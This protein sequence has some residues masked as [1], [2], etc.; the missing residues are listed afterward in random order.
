MNGVVLW[1]A[2]AVVD[3][4]G[5]YGSV[6][7]NYYWKYPALQPRMEFI[8]DKAPKKPR[9]LKA[10]WTSD[11]YFL[12]W[13]APRGKKWNDVATKYVVYKYDAG[14]KINIEDVSKIVAITSQ[15]F[16]KLPY[17]NGKAKYTY[18]VTSIDRMSN[19]SKVKKKRV[20]L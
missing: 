16:I 8:D 17:D 10:L 7:R 4:I 11:G 5:N 13:Q 12:F 9:K 15:T 19:E 3:N 18:V 20:K 14:E 2:K 6:L 1:Y